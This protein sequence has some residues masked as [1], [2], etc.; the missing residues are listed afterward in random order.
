MTTL[1]YR[2]P[3]TGKFVEVVVGGGASPDEVYVG[4]TEP[5]DPE[6]TV[7]VNPAEQGGVDAYTKAEADAKY[8]TKA[9]VDG[10]IWSGTQAQYDALTT[11]DP[12]VLHV[13]KG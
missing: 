3:V 1:N 10:R 6:V 8:A 7:W 12:T 2:D 9:Y 4:P 11:K 5:T 13:V